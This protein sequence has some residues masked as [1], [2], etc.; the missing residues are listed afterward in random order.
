M[1]RSRAP[2]RAS[3]SHS[4]LCQIAA[5]WLRGKGCTVVLIEPQT[6]RT[7]EFPDAIGW[8]NAGA[9]SWLVECKA[10]RED[11]SRDKHKFSRREGATHLGQVRW[12]LA[13]KGLLRA[14]EVPAAWGFLETAGKQVKI[15]RRPPELDRTTET[16]PL[17]PGTTRYEMSLLLAQLERV[18]Q[19]LPTHVQVN[20]SR[21]TPFREF[22]RMRE[23]NEAL[24][25][26]MLALKDEFSRGREPL[27]RDET[28]LLIDSILSAVG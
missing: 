20:N 2:S 26:R 3:L 11:F 6:L 17:D 15:V 16:K 5:R 10:S 28:I 8:R 13:P 21:R 12:Y 18:T 24:R 9:W 7:D 27:S 1:S 4:D 14:E 23:R 22:L 25:A 19:E